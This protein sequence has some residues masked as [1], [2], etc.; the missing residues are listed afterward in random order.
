MAK[1]VKS[2]KHGKKEDDLYEPT[3]FKVSPNHRVHRTKRKFMGKKH[4]YAH[5]VLYRQKLAK[6][7][8]EE[9]NNEE[10]EITQN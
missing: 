1:E 6:L 10:K 3:H 5:I 4:R 7:K 8:E 9:L 2:F